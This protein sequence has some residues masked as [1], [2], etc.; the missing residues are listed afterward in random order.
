MTAKEKALGIIDKH[1]N[2][3]A[4]WGSE[5]LAII[6]CAII[7]VTQIK[8]ALIDRVSEACDLKNME[9]EL[10]FWDDVIEEIIKKQS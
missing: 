5:R 8:C 6:E 3:V 9:H 2:I 10:R 4:I 1:M 7:T